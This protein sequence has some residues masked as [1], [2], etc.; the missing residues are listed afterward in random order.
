M[1]L[2]TA[3]SLNVVARFTD[4]GMLKGTTRD[5]SA[6]KPD[7]HVYPD[8]NVNAKAVKVPVARLKAVFFVKSLEGNKEH[9][10][11]HDASGQGQGRRLKVIFKDGEI[12]TGFT[13]GYAPDRPGFFLVPVDAGSNNL[14][15]FVVRS[16][17]AKVEFPAGAQPAQPGLR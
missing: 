15:I 3:S 10:E 14:R 16:A 17:V 6:N 8:G 7:F 9:V 2:D 1:A 13:V 12:L 11:A 4:G 5:F